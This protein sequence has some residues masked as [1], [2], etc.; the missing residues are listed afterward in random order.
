VTRSVPALATLWVRAPI[1]WDGRPGK[2]EKMNAA[3]YIT[4]VSQVA[5]LSE[6]EKAELEPVGQKFAFRTNEYYQGLINWK[7][8]AD[9]IRR[10]IIPAKEELDDWGNI[11]ASDEKRF[12][13]VSG[14]EHKYTDTA[15]LLVT[16][17]CGAYCRFCFRKRLFM[18]GNDEVV[19]DIGPALAYIRSHREIT[20]V[21]LS[22]G[23][24]LILSTERLAS[25]VARLNAI[26]HVRIIRIGSKMP[27]HNPARIVNDRGFLEMIQEYSADSKKIYLMAHFNHPRE[28]TELAVRALDLC[29]KAGANTVNQTPLIAGVND[30]P[31]VLRDLFNALSFIGVPPYYVFQCRP[32]LGDKAYS[33]SLEDAY[34]IFA[35]A[36]AACSGLAKRAR[37]VMSHVTGKIEVVGKT[38]GNVYMKY[39]QCVDPADANR[40]MVFRSNPKAHWFDDY[41]EARKM[42]DQIAQRAQTYETGEDLPVQRAEGI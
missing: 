3:K 6:N 22:G 35:E 21:V 19:R 42:A 18:D 7:D 36:T 20:N 9:P 1:E 33:V 31:R 23:D 29:Q 24:P 30:D 4:K 16:D 11:D 12:T 25:I 2:D 5:E 8:P 15:L 14:L 27:A 32:T 38:L 40:L 41:D 34:E 13:K 39:H 17:A 10:I 28:L 37:F 26:D